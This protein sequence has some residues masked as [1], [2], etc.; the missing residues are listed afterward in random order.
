MWWLM[1]VVPALGRLRQGD[2]PKLW[3]STGYTVRS[4]L[5]ENNLVLYHID[6]FIPNLNIK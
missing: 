6:N 4:Y 2:C 5:K 3:L 1:P